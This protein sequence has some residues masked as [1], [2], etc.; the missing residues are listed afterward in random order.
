MCYD[1]KTSLE[2]QLRRAEFISDGA[3]IKELKEK[4]KPFI[5]SNLYHASGYAHPKTLIYPDSSPHQPVV[6]I[7]GLIPAWVKGQEKK[8]QLWNAT[9]N[10]RGE[11]IFEK[12]SFR[13]SAKNKRCIIV[14]D[15][16]YEH[17][18]KSGKTFP[19]FIQS[20]SGKPLTVAG[21]WSEWI[22]RETGEVVN[23][24]T[25]VTT[26]A[27]SLLSKIHN[28]PKLKESRMPV[29]LAD[30][31]IDTWLRPIISNEDKEEITALIKPWEADELKAFTV[32]R[33]RGKEAIGNVPQATEEYHY[34]EL[35]EE[36]F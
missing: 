4:L 15:G 34:P 5:E 20:K 2:S 13:D 12:P 17:H 24:F 32:R 6:S 25:I 21:L 29:I 7:W 27:N 9:L 36:L 14:L 28:N 16:F 30:G 10:A 35:A 26:K 31:D 18:H 22:D 8:Q 11:T 19:Y 33:L 23:S 1:I 3:A